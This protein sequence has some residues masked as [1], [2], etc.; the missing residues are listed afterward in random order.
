LMKLGIESGNYIRNLAILCTG[1][2]TK[3]EFITNKDSF[4]LHDAVIVGHM[5]RL[6]K[7]YDHLLYSVSSDKG[8]I[9]SIFSRLL[10]ETY[11][12]MKYLIINGKS[13]IDSFIKSS[14]KSTMEDYKY[15]KEREKERP[16]LNIEKRMV[17]KIENRINKVNLSID[18]LMTNKHWKLD[19]RSFRQILDFLNDRDKSFEWGKAY[20]FLFGSQSAY[21]HGTWYDIQIN[22]LE[23]SGTGF[24]PKY[25]HDRVDPRYI[26]P[27]SLIPIKASIDFLNWRK[28]DPDRFTINVLEK[29]A[30]LLLY[31]NEMDEI[32]IDKK[33]AKSNELQ[34]D[35]VK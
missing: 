20:S 31:L 24:L 14:F 33:A 18:D 2:L 34:K 10:F 7:L 3:D 27:Q 23:E 32:R 1:S 12:I 5:V 30:K 28:S 8:E 21:I 13:S 15:I 35:V 17:R 26:L 19:N 16:L 22:H 4:E 9:A 29:M 6:F 11:T 25:S